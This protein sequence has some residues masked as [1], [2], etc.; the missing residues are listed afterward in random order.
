L[1]PRDESRAWN[2]FNARDVMAIKSPI[3]GI[4]I[5]R[6]Y[7]QALSLMQISNATYSSIA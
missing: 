5:A 3:W 1:E 4:M 7:V 2:A 6:R